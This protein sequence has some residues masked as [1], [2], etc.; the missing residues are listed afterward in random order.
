MGTKGRSD[1]AKLREFMSAS[2]SIT[3]EGQ[4]MRACLNRPDKLNAFSADLVDG[5]HDAVRA[6]EQ[7]DVRL[8]VFTGAGKGFSGGF[9][10]SGLE[11]MSDGDLVLR[12][13]RVEELLQAVYHAPFATLALAH[14]PCYGAAADLLAACQRRV[15]TPD[16]RFR[17]PGLN[18]GIVLGTGRLTRLV[19]A[20]TAQSLLLR[21]APFSAEEAK[22]CGFIQE[23]EDQANWPE[24]ER[25]ALKAALS[26]S[27]ENFKAMRARTSQSDRNDDMAALVRSAASGSVKSRIAAYLQALKDAKS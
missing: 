2:V 20:D 18:F 7:E 23:I 12:F 8:L 1:A 21:S 27:A 4:V 9:D 14:G 26:V 22:T 15:C 10:L 3:R 17:M 19:G 6:A 13:V 11:E 24:V 16:A 25:R 5:L